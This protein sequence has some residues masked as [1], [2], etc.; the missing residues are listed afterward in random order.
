M[1]LNPNP[2]PIGEVQ[3]ISAIQQLIIKLQ[4]QWDVEVPSVD[5]PWWK[6]WAQRCSLHIATLF[7]LN[8]V[9]DLVIAIDKEL[10]ASADKKA[11]VLDAMNALYDYTVKEILPI[12]AKPIAG[13]IKNY[14]IYILISNTIDWMVSK[15][16]S[17]VWPLTAS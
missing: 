1:V 4:A 9:D 11:T 8:C 14:I 3:Q 10:I 13:P 6:F 7:L 17:A 12:W 5:T 2:N 15:Y 16:H